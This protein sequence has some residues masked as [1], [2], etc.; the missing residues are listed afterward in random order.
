MYRVDTWTGLWGASLFLNGTFGHGNMTCWPKCNVCVLE[1]RISDKKVVGGIYNVLAYYQNASLPNPASVTLSNEIFCLFTVTSADDVALADNNN[2]FKMIPIDSDIDYQNVVVIRIIPKCT[3]GS[4]A[5]IMTVPNTMFTIFPSEKGRGVSVETSP[6][7]LVTISTLDENGLDDNGLDSNGFARPG[8][9]LGIYLNFEW[10][11]DVSSTATSGGVRIGVP[12]D[13]LQSVLV[14]GN[15]VQILDGFT[16]ITSLDVEKA[17]SIL[18]ASL[19]SLSSNSTELELTNIG[20]RMYVETNVP[21]TRVWVSNEGSSWARPNPNPSDG[22]SWIETPSITYFILFGGGGSEL[23]IK[24]DVDD[25]SYDLVVNGDEQLTVTGKI[26]G[27]INSYDDSVVNAPSCD[28]VTIHNNTS[29]CNAGPQNVDFVIVGNLSQNS[30]ILHGRNTCGGE[31][32]LIRVL[33]VLFNI[34]EHTKY[35]YDDHFSPWDLSSYP[36]QVFTEVK[37]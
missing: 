16:N 22:Q 20:G 5:D 9:L 15:N 23:Y 24:G 28:N 4:Q 33:A 26:S 6:P 3:W 1:A 12:P 21:V 31:A 7:N 35:H 32:V 10:N 34:L 27:T 37:V 13:Q 14:T 11:T 18:R 25:S 29:T 30:Q 17:G 2:D 8:R 19:T 36:V